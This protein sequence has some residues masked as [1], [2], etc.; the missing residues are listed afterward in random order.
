VVVLV[1]GR[2]WSARTAFDFEPP[3]G[4]RSLLRALSVAGFAAYA[5][6]IPGYGATPREPGGWLSPTRS[7]EV[8]EAVVG[9]VARRHPALGPPML[10]GWSRG[11][12]T[13][14]MVASRGRV[15]LRGL[16]LFALT[17]DPA[18]SPAYGPPVGPAPALP[19]DAEAARSNFSSPDVASPSV[20]QAFVDVALV[21]DLVRA[22]VCCDDEYVAIRPET[23]RVPTLLIQGGRDPGIKPS[24][25]SLFF[26]RLA[27]ID[28]RWV[29]LGTG[30]HAASLEETAPVFQAAV[31][32]FLAA[33][34]ASAGR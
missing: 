28:K 6:D 16:V 11:A 31:L 20:V 5:V 19:N 7:A 18:A 12:R 25:A 14:A 30:D 34:Q 4:S 21:N 15:A 13:S 24:V 33:A 23:I 9:D 10:L 32:D 1:H 29:V 8:V 26:G 3:E 27:A 17:Y 22:D 2:T